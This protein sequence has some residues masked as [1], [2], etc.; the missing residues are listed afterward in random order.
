MFNLLQWTNVLWCYNNKKY[1]LDFPF[2]KLQILNVI[3]SKI[4][5]EW[6][7]FIYIKIQDLSSHLTYAKFLS[8]ILW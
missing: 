1:E 8:L 5:N 2:P 4:L 6:P 3:Y 7:K